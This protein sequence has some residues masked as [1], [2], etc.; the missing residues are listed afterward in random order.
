MGEI[1]VIWLKAGGAAM[2]SSIAVVF[3]PGGDTWLKLLQRFVIGTVL[4][5]IFAPMIRDWLAWPSGGDYWLAAATLGG[6]VSYLA[7]QLVF[8]QE[9]RLWAK[10]KLGGK[11]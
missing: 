10:G 5:F 9:A 3:M 11:V 6:L 2:G 7:L 4:G 1:M 8:S